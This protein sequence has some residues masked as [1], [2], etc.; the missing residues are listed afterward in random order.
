MLEQLHGAASRGDLTA[1][2]SLISSR[3]D[4]STISVPEHIRLERKSSFIHRLF[5]RS[6]SG[7][8]RSQSTSSSPLP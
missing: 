1:M 8:K 6:I 2:N 4:T 3:L 7:S 5:G